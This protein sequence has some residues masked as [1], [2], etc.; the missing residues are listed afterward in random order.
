MPES[1]LSHV[2]LRL[3]LPEI[4]NVFIQ[5]VIDLKEVIVLDGG[6]ILPDNSGFR[7]YSHDLRGQL[8]EIVIQDSGNTF[9]DKENLAREACKLIAIVGLRGPN[10]AVAPG[11]EVSAPDKD[12]QSGNGWSQGG[13]MDVAGR[14][15]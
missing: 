1:A 11:W 7:V 10:A 3:R 15:R 2:W 14:T 4:E 12:G 8:P 9:Q 6:D 5:A 13:S